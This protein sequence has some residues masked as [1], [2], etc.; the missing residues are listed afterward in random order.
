MVNDFQP[1]D[2]IFVRSRRD[3]SLKDR[4]IG[5]LVKWATGSEYSHVAYFIRPGVTFEVNAFRRAGYGSIN[6][7]AEF[8][9]KQLRFALKV[10][11]RILQQ[12]QRT[13]GS[14]YGWGEVVALLLR[15]KLGIPIYYDNPVTNEC[16][17]VLVK[18]VRAETGVWIVEQTTGDVSPQDLWESPWLK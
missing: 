11:E 10:R 4:V 15:K 5:K 17:E 13:K 2:V 18:A 7:Y 8:D 9:V 16:A 6:D 1:C 14:P 3:P 12:I